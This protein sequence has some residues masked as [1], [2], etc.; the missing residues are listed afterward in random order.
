[1]AFPEENEPLPPVSKSKPSKLEEVTP[2]PVD[3][4]ETGGP[5]YVK[6]DVYRRIWGEVEGLRGKL[7]DLQETNVKLEG[8]EYNEEHNFTKLRRSIKGV[9]DRLLQIDKILFKG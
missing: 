2:A 9:H 7:N 8:S 1:L 5:L 6:I 3:S 4:E